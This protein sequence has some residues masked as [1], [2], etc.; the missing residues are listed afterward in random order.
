[1]FK[2]KKILSER[3]TGSSCEFC[4]RLA[5]RLADLARLP[6]ELIAGQEPAISGLCPSCGCFHGE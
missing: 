1:L 6:I 3:T 4:G 5:F 2:L